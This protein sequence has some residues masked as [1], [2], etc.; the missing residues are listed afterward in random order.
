MLEVPISQEISNLK[1]YYRVRYN[2]DIKYEGQPLLVV[3]NKLQRRER[4]GSREGPTYLIPELC[5]LTGIPDNF[6][7]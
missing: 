5:S 1:E 6:D 7:E 4:T 3:K 2:Q